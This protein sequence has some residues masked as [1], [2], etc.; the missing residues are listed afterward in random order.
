MKPIYRHGDF[1]ALLHLCLWGNRSDLSLFHTIDTHR[2]VELQATGIL[3]HI[4]INDT[5]KWV[6]LSYIKSTI[7]ILNGA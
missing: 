6:S 4:L 5:D 7:R 2:A 3:D 1:E